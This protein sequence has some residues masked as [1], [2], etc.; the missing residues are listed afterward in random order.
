MATVTASLLATPGVALSA[1]AL[2]STSVNGAG[3]VSVASAGPKA[4]VSRSLAV[5]CSAIEKEDASP[6]SR[7]NALALL[8]GV[9]AVGALNSGA[10]PALAA[11]GQAANIWGE[12]KMDTGFKFYE[13]EGFTINLPAKWNPSKEI[14]FPG[15]VVRYEDNFDQL[16]NMSVS[17]LPCEKK[18]IKEYGSPEAFLKTVSYL[19]GKQSYKG[20]TVSEG[21]FD[22]NSVATANI[23]KA[24]E[25]EVKGK[26]YFYI[27]VLTRT[28]DGT[29]GGR[30][31]Y[32]V[33]TVKDGKLFI[34]KAQA[35]D[36]RW[37]K[38]T[39]K[40]IEGLASSFTV[41]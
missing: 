16:T 39:Q 26:P 17:I 38:G 23:F 18:S 24:E 34:L 37:F 28:G 29:E 4:S 8:A 40:Y 20:K 13:G 12:P 2:S 33:S 10:S 31:Q 21:G 11:Y 36:K 27:S 19:L 5:S 3:F 7:R 1:A 9:A 15:Q 14:E 6:V 41:A 30:H 25:I 22:P 32:I 35:G